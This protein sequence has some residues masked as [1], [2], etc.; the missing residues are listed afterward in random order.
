MKRGGNTRFL[1]FMQ[2]FNLSSLNFE[3]RLCTRASVYYRELV[4]V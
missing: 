3:D 4:L 1:A 2:K